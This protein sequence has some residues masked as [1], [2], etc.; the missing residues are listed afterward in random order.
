MKRII[1]GIATAVIITIIAIV[2]VFAIDPPTTS[3]IDNTS[4]YE[5]LLETG[6]MGFLVKFT[7]SYT[8]YP[9]ESANE[10]LIIRVLD[11]GAEVKSTQP[12]AN[13]YFY[14]GWGQN[15]VWIYFSA[16]EVVDYGLTWG[17]ANITVGMYGNPALSWNGTAPN[18]VLGITSWSTGSTTSLGVKIVTLSA[19][20][21]SAWST[22]L[23]DSGT[24]TGYG[25]DY[26]VSVIPDLRS[27]CPQVFSSFVTPAEFHERQHNWTN[28]LTLRNQW[29]GTWLDLTDAAADWGIDAIWLYSL[30]WLAV[31]AA[32]GLVTVTATSRISG[33][34]SGVANS[35]I[36]TKP[37]I[38]VESLTIMFGGLIGFLPWLAAVV[39]FVIYGI[40]IING[41]FFA[42]GY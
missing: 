2:P 16:T 15:T 5:D 34:Y 1:I 4:V 13:P 32:V 25:E 17:S 7:N 29:I 31:M 10:A 38:H 28:A 20:F 9:T 18:E 19:S 33:M 36:D 40:I 35:S 8:T 11:N 39:M 27:M 23:L 42:R 30:I 22:S 3:S 41:I 26:W 14:S 21:Q 24:L 6:D 37:L 12:V